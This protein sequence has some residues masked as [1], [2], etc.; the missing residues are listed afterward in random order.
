MSDGKL[1]SCAGQ[2]RQV[3]CNDRYCGD[4][5]PYGAHWPAGHPKSMEMRN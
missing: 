2:S 1:E 3:N 5:D 4:R